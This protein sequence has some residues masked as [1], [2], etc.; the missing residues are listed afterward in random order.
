LTLAKCASI[1]DRDQLIIGHLSF[2]SP[3]ID[4]I[5]W[6]FDFSLFYMRESSVSVSA[7]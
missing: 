6:G 7:A 4:G 2:H 1:S 5:F 3:Q